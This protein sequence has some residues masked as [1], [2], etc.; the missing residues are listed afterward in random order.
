MV[1]ARTNGATPLVM[2][3]KNGHLSC[4]EYLVE[5]C[6]ADLEQVGSGEC[7]VRNGEDDCLSWCDLVAYRDL[8]YALRIMT[9]LTAFGAA[10]FSLL[11]YI[12]NSLFIRAYGKD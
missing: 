11:I 7:D 6:N 2:A 3:S 5:R 1:S 8:P 4:V 10:R 12:F 9:S